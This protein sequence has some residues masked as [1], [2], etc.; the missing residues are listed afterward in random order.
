M[1]A[2]LACLCACA[3]RPNDGSDKNPTDPDTS[4][5]PTDPTDPS[6]PAGPS[7]PTNPTDPSDPTGPSGTIDLSDIFAKY[8]DP[9]TQNFAVTLDDGESTDYYEYLGYDILNRYEATDGNFYIDYL[10]YD[11]AED[12]YTFYADLGEGEYEIYP[13]GTDDFDAAFSYL[14]I[15]DLS[16]IGDYDFT[17]SGNKYVADDPDA[18]GNAVRGEYVDEDGNAIAWTSFELSIANG[19]IAKIVGVME[20]GVTFAY[21][22]SKQGAVSFTLPSGGT[23]P[24]DPDDPTDPDTDGYVLELT[25]D[26]LFP[27]LND[28]V[29]EHHNGSHAVGGFTVTTTNVLGNTHHDYDVL[30][31]KKETGTMSVS[32]EFTQIVV[33]IESTYDYNNLNK[34]TV[35]VGSAALAVSEHATEHTGVKDGNYEILIH[36]LVYD[37]N[38]TGVQ[39]ITVTN[40]NS[41]A[42][43]ALSIGF[44]GEGGSAPVEPDEPADSSV[45]EAYADR[46]T[47]N[48][49]RR[50]LRIRR[51][52]HSQLL[53]GI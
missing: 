53:C 3:L 10:T 35:S 4:T 30:Q 28:T 42:V 12:V 33:V 5:D 43:Y 52:P 51:Q 37:V 25:R 34:L 20:D 41:N 7:D 8:S 1:L 14:Y 23:T 11:P 49:P 29:Y 24:V 45:F 17:E 47:W 31:F 18:A 16:A 36:T 46:S 39:Q 13:E 6:D 27:D 32:G 44:V 48:F 50:L 26:S 19:D 15:I 9:A 2:R 40:T 21:T 22:F 38:A